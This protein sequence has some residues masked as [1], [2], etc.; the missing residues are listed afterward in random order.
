M[1][2]IYDMMVAFFQK[3]KWAVRTDE[4]NAVLRMSYQGENALYACYGC[5]FEDRNTFAFYTV[6]PTNVPGE[7]RQ[8]VAE[9]LTLANY[10][11]MI[12][13]FELDL[14]DGEVRFKT[15]IDVKDDRLSLALLKQLIYTNVYTTDKYWPGIMSILHNAASAKEAIANIDE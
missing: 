13:N 14:D 4:A 3:A 5:A 6:A 11:L 8:T 7:T 10:G 9:Y 1:G 2:Q 12:G 15:S